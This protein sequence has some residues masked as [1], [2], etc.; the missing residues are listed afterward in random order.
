LIPLQRFVLDRYVAARQ[1]KEAIEIAT[2]CMKVVPDSPELARLAAEV[3]AAAADWQQAISM[4]QQWRELS[5][6][7]PMDADLFIADVYLRLGAPD[8]AL[9]QLEAY[10]RSADASPDAFA[11]VLFLRGKA[12]LL[13]GD[14]AKAGDLLWPL[15]SR[16]KEWR[17][18]WVQL[19][20]ALP[21][22]ASADQ[23]LQRVSTLVAESTVDEQIMLANGWY[24]AGDRLQK[25]ARLTGR[26]RVI[27]DG[28]A[29]RPDASAD[30]FFGRAVM[31]EV[32]G[33]LVNAERGYRRTLELQP[34]HLVATNNLAMVIAKRDGDLSE[35]TGLARRAVRAQPK[36]A[37]LYDTLAFVQRKAKDYQNAAANLRI[38]VDLEPDN[39]NWRLNLADILSDAGEITQALTVVRELETVLPRL[40]DVPA[41]D[42]QRIQSARAKLQQKRTG[43]TSANS[44]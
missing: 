38:A 37:S 31:Y 22:A 6:S 13:K 12:L 34:D 23:W 11:R 41:A 9:R 30:A 43:E 33:D 40:T 7:Q 19:T 24:R 26:A 21:N 8:T 5:L 2:R 39:V 35:A 25:D 16:S 28:L 27:L 4:A 42:V 20:D 3:F 18:A 10:A 1:M 15:A 44:L 29:V 32:E 14:L 36:V 17:A